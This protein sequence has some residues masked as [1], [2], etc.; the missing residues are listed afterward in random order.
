MLSKL[1]YFFYFF[2]AVVW[3]SEIRVANK[4]YRH[5]SKEF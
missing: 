2:S 4:K 5:K 3:N 1:R